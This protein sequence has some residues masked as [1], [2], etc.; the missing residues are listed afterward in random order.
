[1]NRR[2]V[3]GMLGLSVAAGPAMISQTSTVTSSPAIWATPSSGNEVALDREW[4]PAEHLAHVRKE[5]DL[6]TGNADKW[7]AEFVEREW[8]EYL[9]G[10]STYRID[11]IDAD[12]RNMKSF[13]ETA[14]IRMHIE[15]K[16]RRRMNK[17][18][19]Y[20]SQRIQELLGQI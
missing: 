18:K 6:M 12:I 1:M 20:L 10:Y 14:K 4:N 19:S 3:L 7:I 13:S 9:N 15:R 5:Y 17:E 16:A 8:E 2:G 11:N